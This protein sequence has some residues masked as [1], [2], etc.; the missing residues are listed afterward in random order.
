MRRLPSDVAAGLPGSTPIKVGQA[1]AVHRS[2]LVKC[3]Q[4]PWKPGHAGVC[5]TTH[6]CV[7]LSTGV[8]SSL[9][10]A[11]RLSLVPLKQPPACEYLVLSITSFLE[12]SSCPP[13]CIGEPTCC[14]NIVYLAIT[15]S[16]WVGKLV[17]FVRNLQ[18]NV[19][20]REEETM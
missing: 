20:T 15:C 6:L 19:G 4:G 2:D 3:R 8:C 17:L 12:N 18:E 11:G 10:P 16:R 14:P 1:Q 5:A 9:H 7:F 13:P